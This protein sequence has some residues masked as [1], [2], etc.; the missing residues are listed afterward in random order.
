MYEPMGFKTT[1]FLLW[2]RANSVFF[3]V[4]TTQNLNQYVFIRLQTCMLGNTMLVSSVEHKPNSFCISPSSFLCRDF[5]FISKNPYV[6]LLVTC[7][8]YLFMFLTK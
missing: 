8:N 6:Y 7:F 1:S 3:A 2:K 5:A 4:V